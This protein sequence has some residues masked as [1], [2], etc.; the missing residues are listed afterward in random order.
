MH[1]PQ[2]ANHLTEIYFT[3][4]A[5]FKLADYS[6]DWFR[7]CNCPLFYVLLMHVEEL[8]CVLLGNLTDHGVATKALDFAIRSKIFKHFNNSSVGI[9]RNYGLDGLVRSSNP[10]RLVRSPS[11]YGMAISALFPTN[12]KAVPVTGRGGP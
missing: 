11:L 7:T 5:Y 6:A 9:E 8:T 2:A 10:G 4:S 12:S 3:H 1:V